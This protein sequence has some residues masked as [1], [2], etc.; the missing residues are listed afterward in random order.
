MLQNQ[1]VHAHILSISVHNYENTDADI[2]KLELKSLSDV[3]S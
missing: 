1:I 2:S 3:P